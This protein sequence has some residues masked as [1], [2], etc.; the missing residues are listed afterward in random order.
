MK[1]SGGMYFAVE[2][3]SMICLYHNEGR[4]RTETNLRTVLTDTEEA[5]RDRA[6]QILG[7]LDAISATDFAA[8]RFHVTDEEPK[9]AET[10]GV[11]GHLPLHP[12]FFLVVRSIQL[13]CVNRALWKPCMDHAS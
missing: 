8:Q 5:M 11:G 13:L 12:A 4:S 3:G 2:A 1:G 10:P 6:C 7:K 9:Q